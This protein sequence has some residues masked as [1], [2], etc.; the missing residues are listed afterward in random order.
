[1]RQTVAHRPALPEHTQHKQR[2]TLNLRADPAAMRVTINAPHLIQKSENLTTLAPR[3]KEKAKKDKGSQGW[4]C[5]SN[6]PASAKF[7]AFFVSHF[8]PATLLLPFVFKRAGWATSCIV[9]AV[10]HLWSYYASVAVFETIRLQ[11]AN[12]KMQ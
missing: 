2:Q 7:Y 6:S 3:K 12:Y 1:M 10:L 4:F 5:C 8:D 11:L 9:L